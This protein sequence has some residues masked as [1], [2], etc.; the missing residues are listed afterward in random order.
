MSNNN[1]TYKGYSLFNDI[2]DNTLKAYNR[3]VTMFNIQEKFND[4]MV[5][6]YAGQLTQ[7]DLNKVY[8]MLQYIKAKGAELVRREIGRGDLRVN[9]PEVTVH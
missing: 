8:A 5:R 6:D 3:A 9:L 4:K 1:N 7:S 2:T